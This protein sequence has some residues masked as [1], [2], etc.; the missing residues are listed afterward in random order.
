MIGAVRVMSNHE[1]VEGA[2]SDLVARDHW[3]VVILYEVDRQ[4]LTTS[5]DLP[6]Q[7]GLPSFDQ[8]R[9]GDR[10]RVEYNPN[11]PAYGIPGSAKKLFISDLKDIGLLGIFLLFASA[12][13]EFNIQRRLGGHSRTDEV[14]TGLH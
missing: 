4:Q 1:I 14:H 2:V 12:F 6:D 13:F 7:L 8:L 9:V 10:V 3:T 5:T 11:A